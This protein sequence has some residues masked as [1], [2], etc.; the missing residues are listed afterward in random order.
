MGQIHYGQQV[1]FNTA[2][3]NKYTL[4]LKFF[5][6]SLQRHLWFFSI[7][8]YYH[9]LLMQLGSKLLNLKSFSIKLP[10]KT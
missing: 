4:K 6:Q 2:R 5:F 10:H 3:C 7:A 1:L 8:D 9:F